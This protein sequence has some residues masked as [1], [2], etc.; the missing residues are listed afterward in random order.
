L[1]TDKRAYWYFGFVLAILGVISAAS[2]FLAH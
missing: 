2:G 1:L